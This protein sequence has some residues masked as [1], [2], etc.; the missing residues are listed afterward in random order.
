MKCLRANNPGERDRYYEKA[1][2]ARLDQ[3]QGR[4]RVNA[5]E[6][7]SMLYL[8]TGRW[9]IEEALQTL[10][11]FC[12]C[13]GALGR[14]APALKMIENG[15]Q[16]CTDH[17]CSEQLIAMANNVE[18]MNV[19]LSAANNGAGCLNVSYDVL[20][21]VCAQAL[22]A[23]DLCMKTREE[24]KRCHIRR[25]YDMIPAMKLAAKQNSM[26][27]AQCPYVGLEVEDEDGEL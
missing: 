2:L 13:A 12:R 17:I 3:E 16:K 18:G 8:I 25:A 1:A 10:R 5:A 23:C 20:N 7:Q 21:T 15:I 14:L 26:D 6:H 4:V 27:A 11:P 22:S 19:T 24:S 9:L